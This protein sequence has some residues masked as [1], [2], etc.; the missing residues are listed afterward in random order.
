MGRL[1]K[2]LDWASGVPAGEAEEAR[3]AE[4]EIYVGDEGE[5]GRVNELEERTPT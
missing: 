2:R 1:V 5:V 4:E 3:M